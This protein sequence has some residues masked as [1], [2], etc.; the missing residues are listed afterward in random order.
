MIRKRKIQEAIPARAV[1]FAR[2]SSREQERGD[3]IEAQIKTVRDYCELKSIPILKEYQITES[4]TKGERKKFYEM[5]NFIKKQDGKIIIVANTIDRIQ[6]RFNEYIDLDKLRKT[7]K[8]EIHFIRENLNVTM[9][10]N[11]FEIGTWIQGVLWANL[12]TMQSSDNIKRANDLS[13][14]KGRWL[15]MAP[16][17]YRNYRDETGF[18][19]VEIDSIKGPLVKKLFEEYAKGGYSLSKLANL[20]N[21]LGLKTKKG[22]PIKKKHI[23]NIIHNPFY[24]GIQSIKGVLRPH[25]HGNIITKE[26]FDKVQ[27]VAQGRYKASF[28]KKVST[29]PLNGLIYCEKCGG[30]MTCERHIK[31]SG[32]EYVYLKCNHYYGNCDQKAIKEEVILSDIKRDIIDK[33]SFDNETLDLI[34]K[35]SKKVFEKDNEEALLL[36]KQSEMQLKEIQSKKSKC[37]DLLIE[38]ALD[39]SSY[40][41]K[42][43]ELANEEIILKERLNTYSEVDANIEQDIKNVIE[44]AGNLGF[45]F[46]SSIQHEKQQLLNLLVSNSPARD[47]SVCFNIKKPFDLMLKNEI[48]PKWWVMRD[49]NPRPSRCKRDALAN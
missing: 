44:F 31:K 6:R 34:L 29:F 9:Q 32:K 17:G 21:T 41:K 49:S 47:L 19:C 22:L 33:L 28:T 3:S 27:D 7:D 12:Y 43:S 18:A 15:H 2:V 10:S 4:S 25:I 23:D 40:D 36:K 42:I 26:L 48:G 11:S 13:R 46:E 5:L 35:E 39:K 20:A 24:Y 45:Y 30:Q 1:L 14:D 37:V 16:M 8:I 38:G